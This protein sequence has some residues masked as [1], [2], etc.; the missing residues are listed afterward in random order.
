MVEQELIITVDERRQVSATLGRPAGGR[1]PAAGLVLAHGAGNDRNHPLLVLLSRGLTGEGYGVLRF[2]FPYRESG[3][4]TPDSQPVL[5]RSWK[6][7][8]ETLRQHVVA[9]GPVFAAGKSMGGRVASQMAAAGT[10]SAAGLILLGYPLHAPG[11]T[12]RLRAAHLGKIACPMLFF[13]GSRDPLCSL[14]HLLRMLNGLRV[15][16]ELEVIDE[17][18]HSFHMPAAV[19]SPPEQIYRRLLRRSTDW[20]ARVRKGL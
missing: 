19:N 20:L 12:D 6:A 5:E 1:K 8:F 14:P 15:P 18:D 2:N 7:A 4:K 11:K 17:A 10:L 3:R 16:W 9:G 13:A